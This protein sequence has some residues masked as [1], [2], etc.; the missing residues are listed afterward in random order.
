MLYV[1]GEVGID[2]AIVAVGWGPSSNA[3]FAATHPEII[4][5]MGHTSLGGLGSSFDGNVSSTLQQVYKGEYSVPQAKNINPPSLTD[6]YWDWPKF[7][8]PFEWNGVDNLVFDA[9]C[10]GANNCQ[11]LRIGFVPAVVAYSI[12]RA[13]SLNYKSNNADFATD[14]VIYDIRFKKRRRLTQAWSAWYELASDKPVFA[15]PVI[16][17]VGQAGG[18]SV[19]LE[20]QGADGKPDPFVVGGFI[21]DPTTATPWTLIASEIDGHRFFRFRLSMF[22]NLNTNQGARV[23][24]VQFP[25]CFQ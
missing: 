22:A 13:A 3:L 16:S 5:N 17:P 4:L 15:E 10:A 9:A 18:V 2:G 20:L 11:I 21:A 14:S 12:R 6:G 19:M 25:Y 1:P 24:S 7:Q 8:T 23:T